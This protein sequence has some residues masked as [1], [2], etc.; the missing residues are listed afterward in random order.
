MNSK[1]KLL[2]KVIG[3]I[4]LLVLALGTINSGEKVVKKSTVIMAEPQQVWQVFTAFEELPRM[5]VGVKSVDLPAGEKPGVG[6]EFNLKSDQ[7]DFQAKITEWIDGELMKCDLAMEGTPVGNFQ[8]RVQE[9]EDGFTKLDVQANFNAP[10]PLGG[11]W[12]LPAKQALEYGLAEGFKQ[13]NENFD[14]QE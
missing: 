3:V 7:G 10:P 5:G 11:V 2:L 1:V 9:D 13:L 4:A 6:Y 12:A 14:A 8:V